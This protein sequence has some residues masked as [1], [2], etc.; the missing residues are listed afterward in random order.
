MQAGAAFLIPIL[1][2]IIVGLYLLGPFQKSRGLSQRRRTKWFLRQW[3]TWTWVAVH[4]V[5]ALGFFLIAPVLGNAIDLP[6]LKSDAL[7][8]RTCGAAAYFVALARFRF[9]SYRRKDGE[10]VYLGSVQFFEFLKRSLVGS[11]KQRI[12]KENRT[13][14]THGLNYFTTRGLNRRDRR[15]AAVDAAV[16]RLLQDTLDLRRHE[17]IA[18]QWA[19]N[20]LAMLN[21]QIEP[22]AYVAA[23]MSVLAMYV[24][25]RREL[26]EYLDIGVAASTEERE[27]R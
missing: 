14:T 7:I 24:R 16:L 12:E 21:H 22:D 18:G 1:G 23:Q 10:V 9:G 11:L 17:H 20:S 26:E 6:F 5:L 2:A 3:Q 13:W 15:R 27:V 8:V 4:S 25:D 19:R